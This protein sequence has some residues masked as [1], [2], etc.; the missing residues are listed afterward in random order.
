[1][2]LGSGHSSPHKI[3]SGHSAGSPNIKRLLPVLLALGASAPAWGQTTRVPATTLADFPWRPQA[4]LSASL[5]AP[6]SATL[7]AAQSGIVTKILFTSGQSVAAGQV[8]VQLQNG[9]QA[10]QEALD[11]VKLAQAQRDLARTRKLMTISGSSQSALEQ[12]EAAATEAA[13]QLKLDQANLAQLQIVAPF[14]GTA[15]I[16]RLDPGDYVQA[17]QAALTLTAPGA[18]RVLFAVPQTEATSLAPGDKFTLSAPLGDG[19][20][21][22]ATGTLTALSAQL[23]T[24]TDAR[25]AEGRLDTA[26]PALLAGM[27]GVVDIATGAPQPAFALPSTALNDSMLGPYIFLLKPAGGGNYTASTVYVKILGSAGDN[28]FVTAPGL[29][30]G[31]KIVAMGGFKLADGATVTLATP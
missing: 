23:N 17:G 28:S 7:A 5:A 12:A 30:A 9:P 31:R 8:L 20:N 6:E 1:M 27:T 22:T 26:P 21:V 19:T 15:G 14:A 2:R 4:E 16:R 29:Q 13:A 11:A 25:D 24:A 3:S 18:L 10:A